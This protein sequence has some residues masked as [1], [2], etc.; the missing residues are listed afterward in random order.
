MHCDE[1]DSEVQSYEGRNYKKDE[2]VAVSRSP[3]RR[4][5]FGS[6]I[7]LE[8]RSF[9]SAEGSLQAAFGFRCVAI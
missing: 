4:Q 5:M 9:Q 1:T 7:F 3:N 6:D 2:E 8:I